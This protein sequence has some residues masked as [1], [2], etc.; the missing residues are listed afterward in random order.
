MTNEATTMRI[1]RNAAALTT[2]VSIPTRA[3]SWGLERVRRVS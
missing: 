1:D 2:W 3:G